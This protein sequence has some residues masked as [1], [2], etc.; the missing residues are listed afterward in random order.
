M[1]N[2]GTGAGG[3]VGIALE[4]V[5]GTYTVPTV[6]VPIQSESLNFTQDTNWRRAIRQ[7]AD[8]LGATPGNGRVEGDMSME[9]FEN[10][11]PMFLLAARATGVQTGTTPN[12]IQTWKG[13]ANAIP[14]KTLS[15]TVVRNGQVF[16]YVG[17]VV[18]SFTLTVDDTVGLL[19]NP[20]ILGTSE[21][22]QTAPTP[23][24]DATIQNQPFGAGK[25][26]MQIPTAT[27]IF[28]ADGFEFSVDNAGEA[29]YR[30][31]NTGNGAAFVSY[32]DRTTTVSLTRD[33][34]T[35]ADYDA[36]KALT[37]QALTFIASKGTNNSIEVDVPVAFK[38]TYE[39]NLSGTGD[40]VRSAITYQGTID[41]TGNAW[42]I[43]TKNQ[44][45]MSTMLS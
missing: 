21:A 39:V 27:Q 32:G 23:T 34:L 30:M 12:F 24:W 2:P 6:Y 41:S 1:T 9:A 13:N 35:R 10:V 25:Y 5:A 31:Q 44:L 18:S 38:D 11:V 29:Q 36:F 43:I 7:V 15:I 3:L 16:G 20:T 4:T 22:S 19:F 42:T 17:C 14:N 8:P 33:F 28:D 26:N 37:S 45:D 40:L